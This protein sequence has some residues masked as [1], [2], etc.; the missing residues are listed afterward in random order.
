MHDSISD[1]QAHRLTWRPVLSAVWL[2]HSGSSTDLPRPNERSLARRLEPLQHS[3]R[4]ATVAH[5]ASSAPRRQL[6]P[7]LMPRGYVM[8]D[9]AILRVCVGSTVQLLG[10]HAA[11]QTGALRL[12][13][14]QRACPVTTL[15]HLHGIRTLNVP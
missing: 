10:Y 3:L 13:S 8:H 4:R 1:A 15:A 2:P 12:A 11:R 6:L 5:K 7:S 14:L 9:G